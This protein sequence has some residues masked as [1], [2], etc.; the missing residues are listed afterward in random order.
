MLCS[1]INVQSYIWV[2]HIKPISR[3]W[4]IVQ[5]PNFWNIWLSVGGI[6]KLGYT[7]ENLEIRIKPYIKF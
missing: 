7:L 1:F 4:L 6:F 2:F 5:K 3:L